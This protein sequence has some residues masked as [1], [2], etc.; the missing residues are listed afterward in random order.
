MTTATA[1]PA[2]PTTAQPAR[3]GLQV[4]QAPLVPI[5]LASTAGILL[6][7][8]VDVPLPIS[9]IASLASLL[10][11]ALHGLGSRGLPGLLYLWADGCRHVG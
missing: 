3:A 4:W 9:L 7:R 10:A 2:A 8:H 6:D 1:S 5:A 11:F